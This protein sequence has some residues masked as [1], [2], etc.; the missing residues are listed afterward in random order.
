MELV[1]VTLYDKMDF[2]VLI[3]LRILRW[4]DYPGL[5]GQTLNAIT[6]VSRRSRGR[7]EKQKRKRPCDT[8]S[9]RHNPAGFGDGEKGH[10]PRNIRNE[11]L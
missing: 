11:A 6:S 5:S 2:V 3:K 8:K 4:R 9:E 7:F 1:N 10:E